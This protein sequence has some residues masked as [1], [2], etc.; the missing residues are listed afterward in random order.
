MF[1]KSALMGESP[2]QVWLNEEKARAKTLRSVGHATTNVAK[3]TVAWAATEAEDLRVIS[4]SISSLHSHTETLFTALA[5]QIEASRSHLKSIHTHSTALQALKKRQRELQAKVQGK[6]GEAARDELAVV[7][8]QVSTAYAELESDKRRLFQETQREQWDAIIE[9]AAKLMCVASFGNHISDQVPQG[10]LAPGHDLPAFKNGPTISHIMSDFNSQKQDWRGYLPLEIN[11]SNTLTTSS[12][13]ANRDPA[14]KLNNDIYE[15]DVFEADV[16]DEI[17]VSSRLNGLVAP[18]AFKTSGSLDDVASVYVG[19]GVGA[20]GL[21]PVEPVDFEPFNAEPLSDEVENFEPFDAEP[22][23]AEPFDAEPFDAVPVHAIAPIKQSLSTQN[24]S[25]RTVGTNRPLSSLAAAVQEAVSGPLGSVP[26]RDDKKVVGTGA[27]AQ[28]GVGDGVTEMLQS[29]PA[30]V[31]VAHQQQPYRHSQSQEK[32]RMSSLAIALAEAEA[33]GDEQKGVGVGSRLGSVGDGVTEL[34]RGIV[35]DSQV[36]LNTISESPEP[37]VQPVTQETQ[38][39]TSAHPQSHVLQSEETNPY[40]DLGTFVV[41][42]N[43]EQTP[44]NADELTIQVG[45]LVAARNVYEDGWGHGR[46]LR[47]NAEGFFPFNAVYPALSSA[48]V[49]WASADAAPQVIAGVAVSPNPA[50]LY[51][52]GVIGAD[53]YSRIQASLLGVGIDWK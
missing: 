31:M 12:N 23:D 46:V 53:D 1:L 37:Q 13:A 21:I 19:G 4:E 48:G 32:R 16:H 47:T 41:M 45:D 35:P 27:S 52:E 33:G 6:N 15:A 50:I 29:I 26:G 39:H 2:L 10:K 30:A 7:D 28:G 34:L 22:F 20:A 25:Q 43:Y 36:L 11:F 51:S 17:A 8:R 44:G 18:N 9:F 49:G 24:S 38:T 42:F 5:D 14:S 40:G 3:F